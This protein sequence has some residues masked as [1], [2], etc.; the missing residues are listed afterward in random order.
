[1]SNTWL[2]NPRDDAPCT[3][4]VEIGQA[5]EGSLGMAHAFIDTIADCGADAVKFQT[6]IAA[7]ESTQHEPWRTRFSSQDATRID[8][9]QRMEFTE[10]QWLELKTHANDQGLLFLSSPFS[11][12]AV[13]LLI[14]TG[15]A[16]WKTAS[17]ETSNHALIDAM[18]KTGLPMI[19]STG[20]STLTEIDEVVERI[21]AH[22][23]PLALL[24]CTS[25]YPCPA[26]LVGLNVIESFR[27]RYACAAGLS[28]HSATIFPGLAAATLGIQAL[29]IH[30]TLSRDMFGPDVPASVT[31][32]Q[33]RE[34]VEGI[35]FIETMRA[36]P[37]D[38]EVISDNVGSL[39]KIFTKSVVATA[40]LEPGT[41]LSESH[42]TT[43][44]PGSGIPANALGELIGRRLTRAVVPD[45][46]LSY[47]DLE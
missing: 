8:Y 30:L 32:A 45:Q 36:N 6:H 20:M 43:K 39:R 18:A 12:E 1:M 13:E 42:L 28:D 38:K 7:A 34:L 14:K 29:E 24:Q 33:L 40:A 19:V 44:K 35:R 41:V 15:V 4:I 22:N 37:V 9:W 3:I 31:P 25:A 47:D 27:E 21:R 17:G 5:H 46:L 16:G 26:E 10:P 23:V 11:L 2:H